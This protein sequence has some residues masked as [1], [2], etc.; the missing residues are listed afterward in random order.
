[1]NIA[2][3]SDL[4]GDLRIDLPKNLDYL[5]IAGDIVPLRYH[6]YSKVSKDWFEDEFL[7][8]C[9]DQGII[10]NIFIIAGNHDFY[11][12]RHGDEFKKNMYDMSDGKIIYLDNEL[13]ENDDLVVYGTPLCK[14]FGNWA[15][16][17]PQE[18]I[19]EEFDKVPVFP[20]TKPS[21][22]LSHDAPYGVS[23]VL[24]QKNCW[25]ADG[26]HI[27]NKALRELIERTKPDYNLHGH[28]HSTNH[29]VEMLGNTEIR[30]VSI[31]NEDYKIAY[32]PTILTV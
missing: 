14:V 22:I 12:E 20:S 29:D 28:L 31:L 7:T 15:F 26:S 1:M 2:A 6:A 5:F 16:M 10:K 25:W 17:I 8:W 9:M 4:H 21:F 27:G 32:E 18:K 23:D 30:C 3:I 24:L 13:W 19:K 11:L